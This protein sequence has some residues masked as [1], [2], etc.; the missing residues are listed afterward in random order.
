MTNDSNDVPYGNSLADREFVND[1]IQALP[2]SL[3]ATPEVSGCHI[4]AKGSVI[5]FFYE[6]IYGLC[7]RT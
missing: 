3:Q 4:Q 2:E 1:E 5:R 6:L 7:K